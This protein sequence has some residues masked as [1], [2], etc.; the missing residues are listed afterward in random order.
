MAVVSGGWENA[1]PRP[2]S[3]S[4]WVGGWSHAPGS[5]SLDGGSS[6]DAT[7]KFGDIEVTVATTT[8]LPLINMGPAHTGR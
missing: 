4:F 1:G 5:P 7:A 8:A 2:Q 3:W 6:G